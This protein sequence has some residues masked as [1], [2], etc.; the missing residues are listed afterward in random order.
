MKAVMECILTSKTIGTS[1]AKEKIKKISAI[2]LT[3][4]AFYS[5]HFCA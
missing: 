4:I 1:A 3:S 5:N 2:P